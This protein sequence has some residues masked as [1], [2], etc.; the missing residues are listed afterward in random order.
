MLK[1]GFEEG[2]AA[3]R[4]GMKGE[5]DLFSMLKGKEVDKQNASDLQAEGIK[6]AQEIKAGLDKSGPG[7]RYNVSMGAHGPTI[8]E[9]EQLPR[10][11]GSMLTPGVRKK[12][13]VLG[14]K[15]AHWESGGEAEAAEAESKMLR[16]QAGL[17]DRDWYDRTV[18]GGLKNWPTLQ[19]LLAPTEKA[20]LSDLQMQAARGVRAVDPQPATTLIEAAQSS[21]YDPTATNEINAQKIDD[22]LT[23][24]R[25]QTKALSGASQR[26]RDTGYASQEA[27]R[28]EGIQYDDQGE[29]PNEELDLNPEYDGSTPPPAN[30]SPEQV[31]K[32]R[33]YLRSK[34]V[35]R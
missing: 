33:A 3:A 32:R 5:A 11:P 6:R 28:A 30:A 14:G 15:A 7:R 25:A 22:V 2:G 13:D 17:K 29:D 23:K 20:R 12:E 24:Q 31:E 10:A 34:K 26:L 19:G 21:V 16:I 27:V 4:V 35:S 1:G 18:G 9:S 8:S